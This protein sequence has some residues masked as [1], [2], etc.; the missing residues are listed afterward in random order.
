ME[1][2]VIADMYN[3]NLLFRQQEEAHYSRKCFQQV[4]K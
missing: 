3:T 2:V 4:E 1:Y